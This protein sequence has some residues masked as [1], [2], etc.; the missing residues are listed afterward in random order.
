MLNFFRS[1][2]ILY[3]TNWSSGETAIC[4]HTCYGSY[5]KGVDADYQSTSYIL[6]IIYNN[7]RSI[8]V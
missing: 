1:V 4:E 7:I 8:K 3:L 6:K 2:Y 5:Q